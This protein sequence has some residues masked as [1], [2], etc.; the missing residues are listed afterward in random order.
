M[1]L[2][3][4]LDKRATLITQARAVLDQAEKESRDLTAEEQKQWDA[5]MNE[6]TGLS[7]QIERE[8]RMTSI[9]AELGRSPREAMRPEPDGQGNGR[10]R[11]QFVSRGMRDLT[12]LDEPRWKALAPFADETYRQVFASYLRRGVIPGAW[13]ERSQELQ[14]AL[15]ADSDTAGGYLVTPIQFVDQLV[16][17]IDD[18]VFIR[19]WA[20]VFSVPNAESLGVPSLDADPADADW[21]TEL[22]TGSEDSTMAFGRRQLT[23]HPVAK[24]IKISN[25]LLNKVPDSESLVRDR[26]AYKFGITFEKACL[27]GSGANQPLGVFT[28]A[29]LGI[30]TGRDVSTD[31]T[32]TEMTLDGLT[33]AKFALK[34]QYWPRAR[35]L[36]HRDGVKQIA[37]IKDGNGQYIWRESVREGEPDRLLNLPVAM[38]EYAPN[39]FTTGLYVGIVGDFGNYWIADS[40][41]MTLQRLVELYAETN[42]VGL[43]GRLESDGMPV[44]EEAFVRV[45]LA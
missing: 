36:F 4:L 8:G 10:M 16:R 20:T 17:A 12:S 43:I 15:Q 32:T 14:A 1:K 38:S 13:Q 9:E 5:F 7:A 2:R 18:A 39:T 45:K 19:Q 3:E 6:A 26:L 22:A 29:A 35:W 42:Q 44:L 41:A 24:R 30:S 33:N 40:M 28:A 34:G 25:K 27:T 11:L 23:P 37:K 21:T 31:N